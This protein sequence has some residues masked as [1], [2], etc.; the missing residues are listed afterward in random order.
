MYLIVGGMRGFGFEV[1][2]WMVEN[3]VKLIGFIGCFK[4]F[5]VKLFEI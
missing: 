4:F 3:G 2:F 5:N 1:V